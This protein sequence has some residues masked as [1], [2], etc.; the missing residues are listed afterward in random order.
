M[1]DHTTWTPLAVRAL[2][3]RTDLPT[4]AS[5]LGISR[6]TAYDLVR[7]GEF[8]IPVLRFGTRIIVPVAGLLTALSVGGDP[9]PAS[10]VT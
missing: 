1:T 8:P 4:A 2:G 9:G 10:A 5:V 7:T 3:V 6:S